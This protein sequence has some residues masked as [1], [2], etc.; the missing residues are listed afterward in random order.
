[1]NPGV[2]AVL[3]SPEEAAQALSVSRS[4][5]YLLLRE[6]ALPSIKI[7]RA[8]RIPSAALEELV[9]QRLARAAS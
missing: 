2:P 1:M 8:R 7:G 5:V 3:L 4:M 6:G 9:E